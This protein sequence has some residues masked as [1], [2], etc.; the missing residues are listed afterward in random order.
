MTVDEA[1][2]SWR[3]KI[4]F[5]PME[6]IDEAKARWRKQLVEEMALAGIR[7]DQIP[8]EV[9]ASSIDEFLEDEYR[10]FIEVKGGFRGYKEPF[11]KL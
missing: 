5:D 4:T 2:A 7:E 9:D 8:E 11:K 3:S 10:G 6:P 1:L